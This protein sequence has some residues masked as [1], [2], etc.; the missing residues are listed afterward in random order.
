MAVQHNFYS[1]FLPRASS[2]TTRLTEAELRGAAGTQQEAEEWIQLDH[3][4]KY[5]LIVA[6]TAVC[7]QHQHEIGLEIYRQLLVRFKT[8]IGT[9]SIGCLT[10][11][12]WTNIWHQQVWRI[13]QQLGIRHSTIWIRQQCT[14][15]RSSESG[16]SDEQNKRTIAATP[17]PQCSSI[18]NICRNAN[19]NHR[20]STSIHNIQQNT[21]QSAIS[22]FNKLQRRNSTNGHRSNQQRKVQ[23]QRRGQHTKERKARTATKERV[24]EAMVNINRRQTTT[25]EEKENKLDKECPSKSPQDKE[26]DQSYATSVVNQDTQWKHAEFQCITAT[27]VHKVT[28]RTSTQHNS[29][30]NN[31]AATIHAGG[32]MINYQQIHRNRHNRHH[33]QQHKIRYH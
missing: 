7:R 14:I 23:G 13:I 8:P 19:N 22:S 9:R 6:A 17:T 16:S 3:N 18:T 26:K 2:S 27:K 1:Q 29:G 5:V 33:H 30:S 32:T 4:L 11:L 31:Q 12:V 24:T 25:H 21:A 10:K 28:S 20:V 15:T